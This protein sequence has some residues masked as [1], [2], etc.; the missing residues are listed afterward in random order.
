MSVLALF[1]GMGV[2]AFWMMCYCVVALITYYNSKDEYTRAGNIFMSCFVFTLMFVLLGHAIV[3][4][5]TEKMSPVPKFAESVTELPIQTLMIDGQ[6][7]SVVAYGK[8]ELIV[9]PVKYIVDHDVTPETKIY[10]VKERGRLWGMYYIPS[11]SILT[12][13]LIKVSKE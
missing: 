9:R 2:I 4:A 1:Y 13:K 7:V 8:Q 10:L 3:I 6:P 11:R 5:V 12:D